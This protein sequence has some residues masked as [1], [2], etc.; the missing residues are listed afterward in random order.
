MSDL[1]LKT[2]ATRHVPVRYLEGGSGEPLVYLHGAGGITAADPLLAALAQTHHVYA[3][4]IPGYGDSEEAPEI[5]DMLDFTLHTWDVVGALGLKD[6]IL[7][8]HSM[9][10]MIAAEMA[11]IA[12]NDVSRLALLAPMGL[13][14]DDHPIPDMFALLPYELPQYLFHDPVAGAALMGARQG[15]ADP[16]FLKAFLIQ[17]ARQMGMAGRILFPIPE[18]GLSE[19]LYRIKAKTVVAWGES[20]RLI[21]PV[22]A[23]AFVDAI[24]GAERVMAPQAGHMLGWEQTAAVVQAVGRL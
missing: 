2:L 14:L 15:M 11:A 4:L 1:Q 16:E 12:P 8:G 6:P 13:W 21:P 20:D 24:A 22:Y 9:G 23:R 7:V 18:R 19:R 10:G 17:N 3:P 5:R